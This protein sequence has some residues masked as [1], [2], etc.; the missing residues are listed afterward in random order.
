MAVFLFVKNNQEK[1]FLDHVKNAPLVTL[2]EGENNSF[3][4]SSTK[5]NLFLVAEKRCY[6]VQEL[7][8]I[9]TMARVRQSITF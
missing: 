1:L 4:I 9:L 2:S 6:I 7:Q 5:R 3:Q 8:E